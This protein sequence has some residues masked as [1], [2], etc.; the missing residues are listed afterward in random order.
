M[1][2]VD[3]PKRT[4]AQ[5]PEQRHARH[6]PQDELQV[7]VLADVRA[8]VRLADGHCQDRVGHHPGDDHVGAHGAVVVFLLLGLADAGAGDL[9]A[10]AEVAQGFVVAGVDVELLAGHLELDGVALADGGAEVDVDDVVAFGAP[11]DVVG[12]AEGVDLEGADVRGQ[13]G[14]VL[15]RGGEHVPG[16]EV[17]EGHEEVEADGGGRGDDEVGEDVVAEFEGGVRGSELADDDVESREGG[18][19]HHDGIDDYAGHEHSFGSKH[20]LAEYGKGWGVG[21]AYP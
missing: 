18:V 7:E 3:D 2:D 6:R 9:E 1:D 5:R 15:R 13:E 20:G 14:E 21:L 10:V 12:V 16:V 8:V 17:E 19:G 11:G 4:A